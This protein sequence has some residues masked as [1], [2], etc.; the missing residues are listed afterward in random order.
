[1]DS[2]GLI[3]RP[4][5][6][7]GPAHR[8]GS[9]PLTGVRVEAHL[10]G[11]SARIRLE[12]RYKN[13]EPTPIEAVYTFPLQADAV[14]CGFS[15]QIGDRTVKGEVDEREA[16]FARYDDA[17][18]AG[19]AAILVDQERPDVFTAS[20]GNLLPGEEA[21]L[22]LEL[23]QPLRREGDAWRFT[24]PTTVAPRFVPGGRESEPSGMPTSDVLN[25]PVAGRVP[26]GLSFRAHIDGEI[27]RAESPSHPIRTE[28]HDDHVV[29]E[30]SHDQVGMDRDLVLLVEP[31]SED[32]A[33][34]HTA[35]GPDG[36]HYL[37]IEWLVPEGADHAE[38]RAI[39]TEARAPHEFIF[40][41]DCSG[42][43]AGRNIDQ[44]RAALG[45]C[46][47]ALEEG[48]RFDIITFG[49]THSALFGGPRA[50]DEASAACALATVA[51]MDANLGGTM[52]LPAL[53]SALAG[54]AAPTGTPGPRRD[55]LL[56][57]DGHVSNET[58]VIELARAHRNQVRIS[59]F[60]IGMAA[61]SALVQGLAHWTEGLSEAIHPGERIEPKVLRVFG[62]LRAE[63]LPLQVSIKADLAQPLPATVYGGDLLRAWFRLEGDAPTEVTVT[64]GAH[65]RTLSVLRPTGD[66]VGPLLWAHQRIRAI[67]GGT[68][69]RGSAQL[70]A[71][72]G[73]RHVAELV[74]LGKNF[75]IISSATS[76]VSVIPSE[77]GDVQAPVELRRVPTLPAPFGHVW[78]RRSATFPQMPAWE[79]GTSQHDVPSFSGMAMMAGPR[80]AGFPEA[81]ADRSFAEPD[82]A[83]DALL[84]LLHTQEVSG[85]FSRSE[86][87]LKWLQDHLSEA[88]LER[89]MTRPDAWTWFALAVLERH[90]ADRRADWRAAAAKAR[91]ALGSTG[92]D[93]EMRLLLRSAELA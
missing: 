13:P 65:Q 10:V 55:I 24:L 59:T 36:A 14:V 83:V 91:R 67:E 46:L 72:R 29:I 37:G 54:V 76:Y 7:S 48:D 49:S 60:G 92:P 51:G 77:S 35:P 93:A 27:R 32:F 39:E 8:K 15:G 30:L 85:H 41:V 82:G 17:M 43:M 6:E 16:A 56:L 45:L 44:A 70:R 86:A 64:A 19:H 71:G 34:A 84:E 80:D 88:D 25:P 3:Y 1:M 9:I 73:D 53:E 42:S 40:V 79:S 38:D 66:P 90:F 28:L 22:V 61:G 89:A 75:G 18:A 58:E 33:V 87:L 4:I 62:R 81:D 68:A 57:T 26:Y 11:G 31:R 50:Y 78:L 12:Q 74:E 21:V 23:I 69:G 47:R 63:R 2:I 52:V 5:S 20:V